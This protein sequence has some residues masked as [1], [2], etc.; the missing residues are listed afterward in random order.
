[1]S[2]AG[3]ARRPGEEDIFLIFSFE[4]FFFDL[5]SLAQVRASTADPR[6]GGGKGSRTRWSPGGEYAL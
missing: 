1:V 4:K 3:G 5:F 2:W 6:G